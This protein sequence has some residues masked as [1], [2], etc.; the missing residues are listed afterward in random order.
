MSTA[1]AVR[2]TLGSRFAAVARSRPDAIAIDSADGSLTYRELDERANTVAN[3]LA[4]SGA[5]SKRPVG[6]LATDPRSF[7]SA[8]V[9]ALKGGWFYVPLDPLWPPERMAKIVREAAAGLVLA[10]A[11]SLAAEIPVPVLDPD[12]ADDSGP[13]VPYDQEIAFI[14]YTSGSTG[15]PKGVVR[16]HANTLSGAA[17]NANA[18][19][20]RAGDRVAWLASPATGV[21]S[22]EAFDALLAGAT[23][24]PIATAAVPLTSVVRA[25][26]DRRVQIVKTVPA[27]FRHLASVAGDELRDSDIRLVR[28]SGE[29]AYARDLELF[30]RAFP[31]GARLQVGLASTEAGPITCFTLDGSSRVE[32]GLLPTG[33]AGEEG[34]ALRD[35]SGREPGEGEAGELIA[36]GPRV[37]PGLWEGGAIRPVAIEGALATGDL[38]RRGADGLLYFAGRRDAMVKVRGHRVDPTEIEARLLAHEGIDEAAVVG[39]NDEEGDVRLHAFVSAREGLVEHLRAHLAKTLP[40]WMIP[41]RIEHCGD[42]PRLAT[43]KIDRAAL[44]ERAR[45]DSVA[46]AP[47]APID[48]D[49]LTEHIRLLWCE[50]LGVRRARAGDDFFEQ[51]GDSLLAAQLAA[52][53]EQ[54]LGA[55]LL[56]STLLERWTFAGLVE[57]VRNQSEHA[58][59][60]L[61]TLNAGG[62]SPPL[63]IV[64]G[65]GGNVLRFRPLARELG[66]DQ[67]VYALQA[68]GLD[69]SPDIPDSV[70]ELAARYLQ[71]IRRTQER[72]PYFLAGYSFGGIVA[73]EMAQQLVAAGERVALLALFDTVGPS[74]RLSRPLRL[75]NQARYFV[76]LPRA[77][78]LERLRRTVNVVTKR[79]AAWLARRASL[80]AVPSAFKRILLANR[81]A[82]AAYR[83]RP[84]PGA[85]VLIRPEWGFRIATREPDFGWAA[86]AGGGLEVRDVPG[87][88][89]TFMWTPHSA[90]LAA[91][92]RRCIAN[93]RERS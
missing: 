16:S 89:D 84:Y 7:V 79:A 21:A 57:S 27:M 80:P 9:G 88:H 12:G 52:R 70:E 61:V 33:R 4:A 65:A 32:G 85:A 45:A 93:A 78:A 75:L 74:R 56:L 2:D 10:R 5:D 37:T 83:P 42:L 3:L 82:F 8:I 46:E 59:D 47:P 39:V 43:G 13:P 35:E 62:T 6:I 87:D 49:A 11:G 51:G 77:E 58:F 34:I 91:E 20:L 38:L 25:L 63:F 26:H 14:V 18:L 17:W 48:G 54:E 68:F 90:T 1:R 28:L 29:P 44:I 41:A 60:V 92:L 36:S 72:G 23:L 24:C 69:G 50:T 30:R 53:I 86:L 66:P 55:T 31:P 73:W 64:N 81:R 22:T 71:R 67:P 15:E 19:G 76:A 40:R